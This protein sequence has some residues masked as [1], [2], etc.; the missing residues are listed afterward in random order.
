MKAVIMAGGEG[1]RLRPLTCTMPKPM[2]PL[3]NKPIVDYTMDLLNEYGV[4]D[5]AF[6]VHYMADTIKKHI[7]DGKKWEADISFSDPGKKLGTAG[8]VRAAAGSEDESENECILVLSGDCLTDIDLDEVLKKHKASG[9][10]A[11]IVLK[12]VAKPTEYGVALTDETGMIERFIEKPEK[13]ELFSDLANTGIY[14]LERRAID[15]IPE[16]TEFDFSKNLFPLMME[17]GMKL[18]GCRTES[19]WCDIGNIEQY[20]RAQQDMLCGRCGFKTSAKNYGGVFIEPNVNISPSAKL[21]S[22]CYIGNGTQIADGVCIEPYTVLGSGCCIESGADLK[23]SVVLENVKI[24]Q[25][26]ELRGTVVCENAFIDERAS[27]YENSVV[28]AGTHIGMCADIMP[29]VSVWPEKRIENG[30]KCRD[31]IVWGRSAR[32]ISIDGSRIEGYADRLLTPESA[33]RIGAGFAQIFNPPVKLGCC[34]DG[35][36]ISVMLKLAAVSGM[37]SQGADVSSCEPMSASAFAYA[38]HETG[39]AGGIY[40]AEGKDR[41]AIL[42]VYDGNGIEVSSPIMREIQKN[43]M[44]GEKQPCIGC[45]L[46]IVNRV[47]GQ[48]DAYQ[49]CLLRG[50]DAEAI[51]ANRK[52]LRISASDMVADC[53]AGILLNLGW[54]VEKTSEQGKLLP[55]H[56]ENILTVAL[57]ENENLSAAAGF[58]TIAGEYALISVILTAEAEKIGINSAMLPVTFPE[59]YIDFIRAAGIEPDFAPEKKDKLRRAAYRKGL[60]NRFLYEPEAM[61]L[62]I[63]ELFSKGELKE[64]LER[65]PNTYSAE[66][67]VRVNSAEIGR[68]LRTITEGEKETD[69]E[70]IDGI[71]MKYDTGWV[72]VKPDF[73]GSTAFRI[74]AGST[75]T[76]YAKELC[77]IYADKINSLRKKGSMDTDENE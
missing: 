16:N 23:R 43:C 39:C 52:I 38:I 17:K 32:G 48:K 37:I 76:E 49:N 9:A 72:V 50:I 20:R 10:D 62:K 19:Y 2:V 25:E 74:V 12:Q 18:F 63:C 28:G 31:N 29:N 51:K 67:N 61:I 27:L 77:D 6:A 59:T 30:S 44:F 71:R 68:L 15:L 45:E 5:I 1:K 58:D 24:R 4:K 11:T 13:N 8:S 57:D 70:L 69:R 3:L 47:N 22:P 53:L 26:A 41:K 73:S 21:L 42:T 7:N 14:I 40:I 56:N 36:Q 33:V 46:G 66:R 75:D 64:R 54:E 65:L 55:A 34:T 35:S 60:Y